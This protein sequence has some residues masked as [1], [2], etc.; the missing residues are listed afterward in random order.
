MIRVGSESG[1][2]RDQLVIDF[3]EIVVDNPTYPRLVGGTREE[4]EREVYDRFLTRVWSLAGC[5]FAS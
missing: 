3:L 2:L 5:T 1:P 4:E